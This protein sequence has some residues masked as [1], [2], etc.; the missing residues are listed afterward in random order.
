M[1]GT[2]LTDED[3]ISMLRTCNARYDRVTTRTFDNDP[4]FCSAA[5]VLRRFG[6][7]DNALEKAG[8]ERAPSHTS[9]YTDEDIIA[10][11]KEAATKVDGHLT[12]SKL[13]DLDDAV[14]PSVVIS[15]FGSWSE[16]KEAAGLEKDA[17]KHNGHSEIYSREDFL[18]ALRDCEEKHGKVTQRIFDD[19]EDFPTSGAIRKR[20]DSWQ[21]AKKEA[22]V[23]ESHMKYETDELLE[24]LRDC[25]ERHGK[26]TASLFDSE[27]KCSPE[28]IQRRFG[29]WNEGKAKA[30]ILN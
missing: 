21:E 24:M 16:A 10:E 29:S 28:T 30:G 7:W 25:Y 8:I 17:R 4:D 6:S 11:L 23:A 3:I 18:Q 27:Y 20:F 13:L 15:R 2:Q 19:D 5:S 22:G 9:K 1:A 26:C 14:P 12:T